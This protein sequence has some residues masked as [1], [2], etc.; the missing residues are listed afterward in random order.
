MVL[1]HVLISCWWCT[2]GS[3][4]G[5]A[6]ILLLSWWGFAREDIFYLQSTTPWWSATPNLHTYSWWLN[7]SGIIRGG[8]WLLTFV[9]TCWGWFNH[10]SGLLTLFITLGSLLKKRPT[11]FGIFSHLKGSI[12]RLFGREQFPPTRT[13][14]L[15]SIPDKRIQEAH[16]GARFM[17]GGRSPAT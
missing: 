10:S 4:L 1:F 13:R 3:S 12:W 14:S 17:R 9:H 7:H 15:K 6:L 2:L 16:V 5:G 8:L 11:L